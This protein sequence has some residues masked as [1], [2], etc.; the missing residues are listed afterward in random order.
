[1][2]RG[3][4]FTPLIMSGLLAAVA[5]SA[6][7][8]IQSAHE[9]AFGI[10]LVD[11]AAEGHR[12]VVVDREPGQYLGHPTTQLLED[13][14][15]LAVYPMGHGGGA[16]V[17]RRSTD[18]GL[19]WSERLPVPESWAT[20]R[21]VPTLFQV[22]RGDGSTRIILFSGLH[23]IRRA[24][25]EDLGSTWS[26]LEPIGDFGGIVAMASLHQRRDGDLLAFFHDDGRFLE[27]SGEAGMF[28]VF[29]TRSRDAGTSWDAP[30]VVAGLADADLCEPG[31]VT[32]PAGDR[33]ALLLRENSRTRES[34]VVFSDDDGDTWSAPT[35]VNRALTG[36]RHVAKYAPDGRLVVTFRDMAADSPTRGDWVLWVGTWDDVAR[37]GAGSYRVRI[38]D[39]LHPWDA[40]YA[41][42]ELLADGTFV[43]TTYGHWTP[44]E[45]PWVVSVRFRM[46]ELDARLAGG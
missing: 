42:L 24:V 4:A 16:I 9:A 1:M 27:G 5:C 8:G 14:T 20:S 17:H 7:G 35:E 15:L 26:E 12:Q 19:T 45:E 43:A 46:E 25:S 38:M 18:G 3:N 28:R 41:G 23:P 30:V 40:A 13:G 32:S 44:D 37:G 11:L 39:N 21:E 31:L 6:D 36:D 29:A 2:N 33:L 22:D 10:P 34:F